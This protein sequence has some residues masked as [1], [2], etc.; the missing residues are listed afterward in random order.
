MQY[1]RFNSF[2]TGIVSNRSGG[3]VSAN[4]AKWLNMEN[5][6]NVSTTFK[7][8]KRER[9]KMRSSVSPF[10]KEEISLKVLTCKICV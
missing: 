5:P 6:K 8:M 7:V 1:L 9:D 2:F 4:Y 10:W 3:T